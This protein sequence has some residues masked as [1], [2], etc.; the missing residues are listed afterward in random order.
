MMTTT[1]DIRARSS[2]SVL[3]DD[4]FQRDGAKPSLLVDPSLHTT[5]S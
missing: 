1:D 5:V 4:R 3:I 2:R